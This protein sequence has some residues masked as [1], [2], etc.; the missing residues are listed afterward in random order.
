[1]DQ[2]QAFDAI[3]AWNSG[4]ANVTGLGD[5]E[6][7]RAVVVTEGVLPA[8]GVQPFLGRWFSSA[9]DTPGTPETVILSYGY[10]Q[11]KFGGDRGVIGRSLTIGASLRDVIGVMPA[12]FRF[13]DL[14]PEMIL[15]QRFQRAPGPNFSFRG[16]AR[17]KRGVTLPQAGADIARML[18]EALKAVGTPP[19]AIATFQMRPDLRSLK[20]D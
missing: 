13:L 1:L 20:Q 17:M 11:R 9:D 12:S 2:N 15:P 14:E 5:P 19:H 8:L 10:W 6:Q 4:T 18:P 7:V 3:G 16:I